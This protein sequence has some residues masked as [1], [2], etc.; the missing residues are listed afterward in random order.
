MEP[1]RILNIWHSPKNNM[2]RITTRRSIWVYNYE[3]KSWKNIDFP[4][5]TIK[6]QKGVKPTNLIREENE[7]KKKNCDIAPT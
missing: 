2:T 5:E 7:N 3:K 6:P 4:F 1:E